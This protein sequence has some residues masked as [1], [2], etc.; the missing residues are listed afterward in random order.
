MKDSP[1]KSEEGRPVGLPLDPK[2]P[3]EIEHDCGT[4]GCDESEGQATDCSDLLFELAGMAGLGG[5]VA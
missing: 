4:K 3:E 5:K 1:R 2:I